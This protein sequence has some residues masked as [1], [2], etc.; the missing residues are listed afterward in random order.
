MTAINTIL[1]IEDSE[2]DI[3]LIQR[4]I[5]DAG[6]KSEVIVKTDGE[7]ALRYLF[8]ALTLPNLVLLDLSLPGMSGLEVLQKIR[9]H[10]KTHLLPVVI[11]TGSDR[12]S[13]KV[14]TLG[15]GADRYVQKPVDFYEFVTRVQELGV[16]YLELKRR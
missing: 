4:A 15:L 11:L 14:A 12:E 6:L 16:Y 10:D 7:T 3:L 8:D 5:K 1:L 9:A 2:T 13:D